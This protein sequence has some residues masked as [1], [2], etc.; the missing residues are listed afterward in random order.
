[1]NT[2]QTQTSQ[3]EPREQDRPDGYVGK[4]RKVR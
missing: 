1:M 2:Q 3:D 4:H